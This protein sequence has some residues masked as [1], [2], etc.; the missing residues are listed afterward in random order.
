MADAG[1]QAPVNQETLGGHG[2]PCRECGAPLSAD[3]RYC[4]NCGARRSDA[5]VDY[6]RYMQQQGSSPEQANASGFA[7]ASSGAE[8]PAK[9]QRDYTPLAAVGGIAVLGVMLL[10]GVLI[11]N[12][13]NDNSS[14]PPP[15]QILKVP[16]SGEET[17]G[18]PESGGGAAHSKGGNTGG[19]GGGKSKGASSES[20]GSNPVEAS[21]QALNELNSKTGNNYVEES[22]KIPDEV[23]TPGKPPPIDKSKPPGGAGEKAETIE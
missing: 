20:G 8:E 11:G 18:S 7:A 15:A 6:R 17:G 2:E 4:L 9:Q 14:S 16:A 12:Q 10:I 5:R 22:K 23:V 21:S 1:V 13:G 3:Q 19:G